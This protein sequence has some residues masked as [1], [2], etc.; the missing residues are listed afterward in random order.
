LTSTLII[1][2]QNE[3]FFIVELLRGANGV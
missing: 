2:Q 1:E 3:W